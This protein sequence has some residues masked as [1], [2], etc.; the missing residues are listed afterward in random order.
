MRVG[1][2]ITEMQMNTFT[3]LTLSVT[4]AASLAAAAGA[5]PQ[6]KMADPKQGDTVKTS[7]QDQLAPGADTVAWHTVGDGP[8][9]VHGKHSFTVKP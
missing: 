4:V 2:A 1:K 9:R 7:P 5:H 6:I 3:T 8:H